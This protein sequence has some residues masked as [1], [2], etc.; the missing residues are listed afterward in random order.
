MAGECDA[1]YKT[2]L[3]L[4]LIAGVRSSGGGHWGLSGPVGDLAEAG[5]R[6]LHDTSRRPLVHVGGALLLA[7]L[8]RDGGHSKSS[9]A[10]VGET[11]DPQT[12]R[13]LYAALQNRLYGKLRRRLLRPC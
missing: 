12:L 2:A 11:F 6:L 7:A 1:T 4:C 9:G 3:S 5:L 10:M 8:L 13:Q